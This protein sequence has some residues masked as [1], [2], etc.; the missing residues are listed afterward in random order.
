MYKTIQS[1]FNQTNRVE[2]ALYYLPQLGRTYNFN[3]FLSNFHSLPLYAMLLRYQGNN[4]SNC[5]HA[6]KGDSFYNNGF[7]FNNLIIKILR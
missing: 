7:L 2:T 5:R 6:P 3:L 1:R 4:Y